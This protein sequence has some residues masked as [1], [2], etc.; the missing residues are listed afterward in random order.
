M[1]LNEFELIDKY[2][3]K[4]IKSPT[5]LIGIGDDCAVL[6]PPAGVNLAVTTDTLVSGVHFFSDCDPRKLGH[7][8]LAVNLSDLA[9]MGAEPAWITL[10][11]TIPSADELWLDQFCRGFFELAH[12]YEAE[13]VGGDLTHGPLSV[14][15]QA[16]GFVSETEVLRRSAAKVGDA[17]FVSGNL[18]DAG[19]AL[20]LLQAKKF[21]PPELLNRL[22][23]PEARVELGLSLRQVANAAIDISDGF[24]ADLKHILDASHVGASVYIDKLP[25]S[26]A[27]KQTMSDEVARELALTSG[28]DYELCFTVSQEKQAQYS[29]LLAEYGC[30][31]V[32][33][34]EKERHLKLMRVDGS[35]YHISKRGYLHFSF[36][37]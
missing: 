5:I 35:I 37:S 19:A 20:A 15:V 29:T 26:S 23:C 1:G 33:Y 3:N 4:K 32:G 10:S 14:T 2:F 22:E 8:C 31:C 7:K 13:L 16:I 30:V 9:A 27:L 36:D 25:L 21:V 11:L 6:K 17:I 28:D 34:I 12:R 18:G 24:L